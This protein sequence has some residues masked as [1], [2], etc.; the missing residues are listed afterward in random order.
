[1][2]D[3]L[4][5]STLPQTDLASIQK[6]RGSDPAVQGQSPNRN[7]RETRVLDK[8]E[9]DPAGLPKGRND[10]P[11]GL[12]L[13]KID[14]AQIIA[15]VTV[16]FNELDEKQAASFLQQLKN[17]EPRFQKILD[18]RLDELEKKF[19]KQIEAKKQEK[20][21][22][23]TSDVQL[24]LGVA[25]T[26]L[27]IIATIFTA[28]AMSGLMIA[29]MAIG[30]ATT[31]LDVVNRGLKA[32]DVQ[33]TDPLDKSGKTKKPLDISIG[34]L[35]R[36][37]I[38]AEFAAGLAKVPP[39]VNKN[40]K[41]AVDKYREELIL[42]TTIVVT[43]LMA[44]ATIS[45]AA[46]G[47]MQAKKLADTGKEVANAGKYLAQISSK[48]ADFAKTNMATIQMVNQS[49]EIGGDVVNLAASV[50]QGSNT[51][52]MAETKFDMRMAESTVNR[53]DSYADAEKAY[54]ER[55][56]S[57]MRNS[58]ESIGDVKKLLAD[59]RAMLNAQL[60]E[61]INAS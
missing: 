61:T 36:M 33:Y 2:A 18:A 19:K 14:A 12:L 21:A 24:G 40:D 15:M 42:G 3:L 41:A 1:M 25:L 38:E 10:L 53:L 47:V 39:W 11:P 16:V 29:G 49:V 23:I 20:N 7:D 26:V 8:K 31:T 9:S 30:A 37:Q 44:A 59:V 32:G 27:G 51:I 28:G 55:I 57:A 6:N 52:M 48:A 54:M 5:V 22:Q 4:G 45:V 35:I 56:Q 46:G 13:K 60:S 43:I 50:Y 58:A 34:G 17:E